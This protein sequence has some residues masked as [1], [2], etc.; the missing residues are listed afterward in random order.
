MYLSD[1]CIISG[2]TQICS[3]QTGKIFWQFNI[4]PDDLAS[5]LEIFKQFPDYKV[6]FNDYTREDYL[7]GGLNPGEVAFHEPV[8]FIEQV[9][10]PKEIA[11]EI[12]GKLMKINGIECLS[13]ISQRPGCIDIH[14]TNQNASKEH[15]IA[16][17]LQLLDVK[18]E[19]TIGVGD[20][21]ND[22]HLFNAVSH[23]IA[24]KNSVKEL[25]ARADV[26]IGDVKDDGFAE[27]L[28]SLI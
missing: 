26:I 1:P 14:V 2:G 10:V 23:K 20:G 3:P 19:N 21:H 5:V 8:Y 24:M 15:A 18:V 28:E 6:L 7:Y 16:E 11:P 27:F 9:F 4:E 13:P 17:L 12:V 25:K 22:L